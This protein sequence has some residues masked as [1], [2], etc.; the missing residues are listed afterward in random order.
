M[1]TPDEIQQAADEAPEREQ[2][3][4]ARFTF[5]DPEDIQQFVDFPLGRTPSP[6]R[7]RGAFQSNVGQNL[8]QELAELERDRPPSPFV[9]QP[10]PTGL[11]EAEFQREQD[12]LLGIDPNKLGE[13]SFLLG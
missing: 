6:L 5:P 1:A 2:A 3:Q 4:P 10:Q 8:L 11:S 13:G 9:A 7:Q 12:R